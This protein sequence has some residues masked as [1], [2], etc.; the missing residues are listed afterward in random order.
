MKTPVLAAPLAAWIVQIAILGATPAPIP[1]VDPSDRDDVVRYYHEVYLASEDYASHHGWTGN[2]ATCNAGTLSTA[3]QDDVIRRVNYFRGMAGV[4][5]E[6]AL[7]PTLNAKC[8][9]AALMMAYNDELDHTPPTD[10]GCY[11]ADGAEAASQSNISLGTNTPFYGPQAVTGQIEDGG[12]N[13]EAVGHRRWI[14]YTEAP[15]EMGHGSIPLGPITKSSDDKASMALWITGDSTS[16]LA[17]DFRFVAWPPEG[18]V[19]S[20]LAFERWSFGLPDDAEN[21]PDF[22]NASV[23]VEHGGNTVPL[24]I[25]YRGKSPDV[26]DPAIVWELDG[27]PMASVPSV[28]ETYTVTITG[29]TGAPQSS[30]SYDVTVINENAFTPIELGGSDN[31][32]IGYDNVYNFAPVPGAQAYELRVA[33]TADGDWNEGAETSPAPQVIDETNASYPLTVTALKA[34]GSRS[35]HLLEQNDT[36]EIDREIQPTATSQLT[37]SQIFRYVGNG[38]YL[39]VQVEE[40]P[41]NWVQIWER[42]GRHGYNVAV[43]DWDKSWSSESVSLAAYA[44]TTVRI[45]FRYVRVNGADWT[46]LP[47]DNPNHI[48]AF[49]DQVQVSNS[50]ELLGESVI[51]IDAA[52]T[53]IAFNPDSEGEYWLQLRPKVADQWFGY[54]SEKIVTA[55]QGTPPSMQ[56]VDTGIDGSGQFF[57]EV[58]SSGYGT[59]TVLSSTNGGA[60]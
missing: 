23:S 60:A 31:A 59:F 16:V 8:Q 49:V 35:F 5:A 50:S 54:G 51:E 9:K 37:F 44:G 13:N 22:T 29:I 1:P 3:I 52:A 12:G 6:I 47:S 40:T 20:S 18:F 27:F 10:W 11:S 46:P 36:I 4:P 2:V 53:S 55:V 57:I 45:R 19:P 56:L 24:S 7:S 34:A 39:R 48:G 30:Y 26:A 43:G 32:Y 42:K 33:A 38:T 15:D 41:G 21:S 14:L 58:E 25:V 28:D 17:D